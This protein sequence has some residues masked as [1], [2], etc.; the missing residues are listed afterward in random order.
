M[1]VLYFRL[2]MI[3]FCSQ[4]QKLCHY[5]LISNSIFAFNSIFTLFYNFKWFYV[6]IFW[7]FLFTT[8]TLSLSFN[9]V[10]KFIFNSIL[11]LF[12]IS[13]ILYYYPFSIYIFYIITKTLYN[14]LPPTFPCLIKFQNLM[15]LFLLSFVSLSCVILEFY[16]HFLFYLISQTF[17]ASKLGN[18]QSN[19]HFNMSSLFIFCY[20]FIWCARTII[21]VTQ[22]FFLLS[23]DWLASTIIL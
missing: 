23:S 2:S 14:Y 7:Y 10:L 9:F 15:Q 8:E 22:L 18:Q 21:Q 3:L 6:I 17:L 20:N 11:V 19:F 13:M 1:Y 5:H 4:R 12:Y 16:H